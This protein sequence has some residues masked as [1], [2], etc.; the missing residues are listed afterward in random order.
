MKASV[1]LLLTKLYCI[2]LCIIQ[3][4]KIWQR[5][6]A[7]KA[8]QGSRTPDLCVCLM[9]PVRWLFHLVSFLPTERAYSACSQPAPSAPLVRPFV[10]RPKSVTL[11]Q[12]LRLSPSLRPLEMKAMPPPPP[13]GGERREGAP[14][15]DA[16]PRRCSLGVAAVCPL[17][18]RASARWGKGRTNE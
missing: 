17:T 2:W 18:R 10:R 14:F 1:F 9:G 11:A 15:D 8:F 5:N 6:E 16:R 3:Q 13:F 12:L 7:I 4:Q